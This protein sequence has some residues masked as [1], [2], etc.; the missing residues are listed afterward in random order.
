LSSMCDVD[1]LASRTI[2]W[3]PSTTMMSPRGPKYAV[4]LRAKNI[5][6]LG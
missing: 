2:L 3:M 1:F 5:L 6:S 4:R